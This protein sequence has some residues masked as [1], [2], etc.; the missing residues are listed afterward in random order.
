MD[1]NELNRND[2]LGNQPGEKYLYT[3][4]GFT[5]L[6]AVMEKVTKQA[7]V[8]YMKQH[9]FDKM[10]LEDTNIDRNTD[11]A[12]NR[13]KYYYRSGCSAL[14]K[15]NAKDQEKSPEISNNNNNNNNNNG[16]K[17]KPKKVVVAKCSLQ[18]S[19]EVN[20]SMKWAG[21]GFVSTARYV[22]NL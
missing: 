17:I 15:A 11:L 7:F 5:L 2:P 10:G 8:D 20:N 12:M 14:D 21:G 3:S 6:S 19:P 18:N 9:V 16:T 1:T 22:D 4:H 13:S